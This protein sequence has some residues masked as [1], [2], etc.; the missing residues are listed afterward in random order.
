MGT[1]ER[2]RRF[3]LGVERIFLPLMAMNANSMD[4]E[5]AGEFRQI[6]PHP[7]FLAI[8][9]ECAVCRPGF[10]LPLRQQLTAA[11]VKTAPKAHVFR[12][13]GAPIIRSDKASVMT[14][15]IAE[16]YE[17]GREIDTFQLTPAIA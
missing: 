10:I 17:L 4:E 11:V 14:L 5:L 6:E 2:I 3:A 15:P 12:A 7:D 1:R 9:H 13:V 8:E 16:E